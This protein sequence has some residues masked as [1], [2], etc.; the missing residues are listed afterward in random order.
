[1]AAA[2]TLLSFMEQGVRG[3]SVCKAVKPIEV[4]CLSLACK[5]MLSW[6]FREARL[7]A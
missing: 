3:A 6:E 1:M 4:K 2:C 5:S 7:S